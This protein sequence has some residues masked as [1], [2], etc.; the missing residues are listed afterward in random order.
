LWQSAGVFRFN[1]D[2][3]PPP[4]RPTGLDLSKSNILLLRARDIARAIGFDFSLARWRRPR[5]PEQRFGFVSIKRLVPP[6]GFEAKNRRFAK[7]V[8]QNTSFLRPLAS[9]LQ[10]CFGFVS[11][12][13]SISPAIAALPEPR[14]LASFLQ[15]AVFYRLGSKRKT[16][17]FAKLV[18]QKTLFL[19]L[20][21]Q[22]P[23]CRRKSSDRRRGSYPSCRIWLAPMC[24][25]TIARLAGVSV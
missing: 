7:L 13:A 19:R 23:L 24:A 20:F 14:G 1:P 16:R 3:A 17:H 22:M 21:E 2:R 10:V 4:D 18:S 12:K 5:V 9:S 25:L 8:S 6:I 15:N 11:Q